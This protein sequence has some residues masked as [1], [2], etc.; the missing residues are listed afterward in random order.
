MWLSHTS[1]SNETLSR[2]IWK[3]NKTGQQFDV[4]G[5]PGTLYGE[6]IVYARNGDMAYW[7]AV[8]DPVAKEGI[9]LCADIAREHHLDDAKMHSV[10]YALCC[11]RAADGSYYRLKP[12]CPHCADDNVSMVNVLDNPPQ[13]KS[14]RIPK[15][16]HDHWK[17]LN[18]DQ[19]R[20]LILDELQRLGLL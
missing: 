3:C 4:Y 15:V 1:F 14:F 18:H 7:S 19:K 9:N 6:W 12:Y 10:A 5:L 13:L 8:T 2:S 17:R 11:D 20:Q 16:E